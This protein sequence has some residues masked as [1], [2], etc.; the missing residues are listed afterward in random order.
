MNCNRQQ[1]ALVGER[2]ISVLP[3]QTQ[4][5]TEKTGARVLVSVLLESR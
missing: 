2:E 1:G 4:R 5:M 3:L